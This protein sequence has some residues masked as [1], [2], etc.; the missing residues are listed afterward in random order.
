MYFPLFVGVLWSLFCYAL[1]CV[2]SSVI[3]LQMYCYYKCSVAFL[4]VP[5]VGLK[6]VIVVF[7][8]HTRLLFN[9]T[10][11]KLHFDTL[12]CKRLKCIYII[13]VSGKLGQGREHTFIRKTLKH[14]KY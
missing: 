12:K 7:L 1:L 3:I 10:T 2:H 6:Y 11:L 5:W 9:T 14:R 8:D 13:Y 4:M